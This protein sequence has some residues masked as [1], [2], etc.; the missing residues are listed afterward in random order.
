MDN[1]NNKSISTAAVKTHT[2]TCKKDAIHRL[3]KYVKDP[4][5]FDNSPEGMAH[6]F[7]WVPC[8][9]NTLGWKYQEKG[10]FQT[11]LNHSNKV[12]SVGG[13]G[14]NQTMQQL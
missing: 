11:F 8:R 1:Y 2:L 10:T 6:Q 9:W 13:I 14:T 4:T 3:K 7:E 5:P 12:N